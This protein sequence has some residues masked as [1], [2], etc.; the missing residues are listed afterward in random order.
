LSAVGIYGGTFDP[1]HLGHLHVI[2]Q[3]LQ[4][5]I[6]DHLL[7]VPAGQPLLRA[8]A[9]VATAAQRR[10]M[11]QLAIGSLWNDVANISHGKNPEVLDYPTQKPEKLLDRI[12]RSA[13][14]EGDLVADFF[15]GSGTTAAVAEKLGR[16]WI[17]S[18]LGKF[19]IHTTRK[20]M[21]NVQRQLKAD[22]KDFRA[23]EILNLGK[24]ERQHYI[25]INENLRLEE[26]LKQV[27]ARE[28]EFVTL[29]LNAY[30]ADTADGFKTFQGKKTHFI[31]HTF[32]I[33][34][35]FLSNP[36]SRSS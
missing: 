1:I 13:S 30:N 14:D 12:I 22:G 35:S 16:K 7:I 20:R 17:V 9:P 36:F 31:K 24:Y 10:A 5:D 15:V 25:G 33:M 19:S 18:D 8:D 2:T 11:C 28:Q 6:I 23:F 26:Q 34:N 3:L 4:R 21:I 27:E 32:S 29:I